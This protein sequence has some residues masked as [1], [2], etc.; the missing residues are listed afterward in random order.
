MNTTIAV[1]QETKE[2]LRQ[3]GEKGESYD[4]IIKKLVEEADW[5]KLDSHWNRILERDTFISLDEL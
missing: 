3:H 1:S 4:R 2:V 5:K